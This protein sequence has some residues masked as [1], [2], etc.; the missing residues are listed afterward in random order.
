MHGKKK[1]LLLTILDGWGFSPVTEGNAIAPARK[2]TYDS[3]LR[4][5]P[6]TRI[7]TSGEAVGLPDRQMGNSEVGHMN[8]GAGRVILMDV[9]R[10]DQMIASGEF[11]RNSVLLDAM[12]RGRTHRLLLMGLCS[13]GGVHSLLTHLYALLKLAK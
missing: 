6:S 1:P 2:P 5:Y 13:D 9:T 7:R 3:L 8:I 4:L 10:I 12:R 11:F